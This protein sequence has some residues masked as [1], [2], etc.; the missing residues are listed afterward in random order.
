MKNIDE[1]LEEY[2]CYSRKQFDELSV[3]K[4]DLRYSIIMLQ[5]MLSYKQGKQFLNLLEQLEEYKTFLIKDI[6]KFM[7]G[8]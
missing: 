5:N 8:M 1:I 6:I 3:L 7:L 2:E 4:S